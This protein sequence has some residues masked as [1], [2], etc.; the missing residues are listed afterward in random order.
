MIGVVAVD[1]EQPALN[2]I[3]KLLQE[4]N[5]VQVHGLFVSAKSFLEYVLVAEERIDLVL[6]DME[7]PGIHGLELARRLRT[8]RPDIQIAFLTAYEEFAREAFDVEAVDYLL[9]PITK[10]DLVRTLKR[11]MKRIVPYKADVGDIEPGKSVQSFGIFVVT[12]EKGEQVQFRNSKGRELLAYL[13]HHDGKPVSKAQILDDIWNGRD[14]EQAQAT[15][16]ST[17]YQ[18]RKDL[19]ICGLHNIINQTKTAG[20]SYRLEWA[21]AY[22]DVSAYEEE[23]CLYK[24]TLSLAHALRAIR[25]YGDGYL[26]GSGYVWAASRQAELELSYVELLE[27]VANTYAR[28]HRYDIALNPM[29]KWS[30]LMPLNERLHAKMVALLLLMNREADATAYHG[31]AVE[32]LTQS[33]ETSLMEFSAIASNPYSLF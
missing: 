14:V 28:Q 18:L 20:G 27:A 22:H 12:T 25:L 16:Y 17:I 33:D 30:Q 9:K 19:E 23:Y 3:G 4:A 24:Q 8:F 1:D 15:L 7:I 5:E 6:L 11:C 2:R 32:L 13:H 29:K 10:E 31:L 26:T 21:V